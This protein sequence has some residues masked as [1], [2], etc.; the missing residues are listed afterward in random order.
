ML[1][2]CCKPPFPSPLYPAS[3]TDDVFLWWHL[4]VA[5]STHLALSRPRAPIYTHTHTHAQGSEGKEF[6]HLSQLHP[7]S[8]G[9][10]E[11]SLDPSMEPK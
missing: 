5:L 9:A 10:R 3:H 2:Q 7:L 11:W 8:P 1:E 6:I 4:K